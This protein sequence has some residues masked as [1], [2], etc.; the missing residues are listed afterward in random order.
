MRRIINNNNYSYKNYLS[1]RNLKNVV[2]YS[3]P[4]FRYFTEEEM[5]NINFFEYTWTT[6]DRLYKLADRFFGTPN[7]W[8]LLLRFNKLKNETDIKAGD[9]LKIPYNIEQLSTLLEG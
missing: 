9:V 7:D 2:Q 6:G 8:W 1:S 5:K 4:K 3:T